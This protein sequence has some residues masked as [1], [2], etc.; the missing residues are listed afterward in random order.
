MNLI[1]YLLFFQCFFLEWITLSLGLL[2]KNLTYL[3]ELTSGIVF[4]IV[5]GRLAAFRMLS[6]PPIVLFLGIIILF[7]FAAGLVA[8]SVQPGAA[9]AG[10]RIYL[11]FLPFL[12]LPIVFNFTD[13]QVRKQLWVM[14]FLALLQ[15]P[16]AFYQKYIQYANL[17]TGDV[18]GGT[19]VFSNRISVFMICVVAFL[20]VFYMR[21]RIKLWHVALA[22]PF[23]VAPTMIN[24]TKVTFVL[25]PIAFA[26]AVLFARPD[27]SAFSG[28][29]I[30]ML[31]MG[32]VSLT[33][34]VL[35]YDLYWGGERGGIVDS[36]I[37]SKSGDTSSYLFRGANTDSSAADGKEFSEIGRF[38]SF[39]L[40]VQYFAKEPLKVAIGVG[41][42]NA[43][44]TSQEVFLG[45][46]GKVF[47][48]FGGD[49][50]TLS[51]MVW[52]IG[53]LGVALS[54][55][56][57]LC[58]FLAAWRLRREDSL[59]GSIGSAWVVVCILCGPVLV[60][61]N[62]ITI[63]SLQLIFWYWSG[64][65]LAKPYWMAREREAELRSAAL[66]QQR[67]KIHA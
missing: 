34:F 43:S 57:M 45:E 35:V 48:N 14:F 51:H 1:V 28:Q 2:P 55:L 11:K 56:F 8:N 44:P 50:T 24:E 36:M 25:L 53:L 62:M 41:I 20:I 16:V 9:F 29:A 27:G 38:D 13:E 65:I 63:W 58:V 37:G 59:A 3:P 10:V 66:K 5:A 19:L 67:E 42:G 49:F 47:E 30:L 46:Y 6:L 33:A 39:V 31:G 18:V 32:A 15:T 64:Y 26:T 17:S 21:K 12:M 22:I 54:L 52:E 40:P 61:M 23:L 7:Y 4:L 60:Y